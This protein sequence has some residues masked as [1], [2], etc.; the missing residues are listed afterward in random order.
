[1]AKS[2]QVLQLVC[3]LPI[4]LHTVPVCFFRNL[5]LT[6]I[7]P[8][9]KFQDLFGTGQ[10]REERTAVLNHRKLLC[11]GSLVHGT[12]FRQ[13]ICQD[14]CAFWPTAFFI[15]SVFCSFPICFL[16]RKIFATVALWQLLMHKIDTHAK[17][18]TV[19]YREFEKKTICMFSLLYLTCTVIKRVRSST[20]FLCVAEIHFIL[21]L[22]WSCRVSL[23][24]RDKNFS[25]SII[26]DPSHPPGREP[27]E[28]K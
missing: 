15:L 19:T 11:C 16:K 24:S 2:Y 26:T 22:L 7:S 21:W 10:Y 12:T 1:M 3:D 8:E 18:N 17:T 6:L 28:F 20:I 14:A 5:S 4:Y 13:I 9:L 23:D 25:N 27:K